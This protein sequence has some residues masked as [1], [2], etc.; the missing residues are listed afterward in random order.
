[1]NNKCQS[2][3]SKTQIDKRCNKAVAKDCLCGV[4]LRTKNVILFNDIQSKIYSLETIPPYNK[5]N[6]ENIKVNLNYYKIKTKNKRDSR[7]LY[8]LLL[9]YLN[10][11][12]IK[13]KKSVIIQ[14]N[15]R[16]HLIKQLKSSVNHEDFYSLDNIIHIP[17]K[18]RY[19]LKESK[20]SYC[21]DL[22]SLFEYFK[23]KEGKIL[24][25]YNNVELSE[26]DIKNIRQRF[27]KYKSENDFQIIQEPLSPRQMQTQQIISV[28]QHYDNLGFILNIE[29]FS[30][31][32]FEQLKYL[33]RK[34]EDIWN[35]R[36]QLT[37]EQKLGI[38][39]NGKLFTIPVLAVNRMRRH[40]DKELRN[41]LLTEFNRAVTEG[42]NDANRRLGAILMLTGF[43]E[44][45]PD[46]INSYPWLSQSF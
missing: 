23:S 32:R 42:A 40:K 27:A 8:T 13:Y 43:A 34:C 3:K 18:Y 17:L 16:R 15:I 30:K 28:F 35:Y 2:V 7:V 41:I 22:R 36:A 19:I 14:K 33:Y 24:N 4:H 25:P 45:S 46:V 26:N 20:V 9:N 1:M 38:V 6:K 31:L 21:F 39:H 5:I 10:E 11:K 29:W 44:V 37:N 12:S